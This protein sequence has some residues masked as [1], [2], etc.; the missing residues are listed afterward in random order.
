MSQL[1]LIPYDIVPIV[2]YAWQ[3]SFDNIQ[4][5]KKAI[6]NRGWWPL[7]RMLLLHSDLRKSM[8]IHDLKQ[9]GE[10]GLF[11]SKRLG[12]RDI[13]QGGLQEASP[14]T[15]S[16]HIDDINSNLKKPTKK[17]PIAENS[18]ITLYANKKVAQQASAYI[19]W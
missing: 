12:N 6:L 16:E 15:S 3:G 1:E 18:N 14:I 13:Y 4:N 7:I 11:P 10:E 2:N 17:H 5:N 9:E 19:D 8:T